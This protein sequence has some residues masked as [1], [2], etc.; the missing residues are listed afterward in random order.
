[1]TGFVGSIVSRFNGA[2][3]IISPRLPGRFESLYYDEPNVINE[4]GSTV[5]LY[6]SA[7]TDADQ[8]YRKGAVITG[9]VKSNV[10]SDRIADEDQRDDHKAGVHLPFEY[11]KQY[12]STRDASIPIH[13]FQ[14]YGQM[15][16]QERLDE[17]R[18]GAKPVQGSDFNDLANGDIHQM[19]AHE[20]INEF[21]KDDTS[22]SIMPQEGLPH[23]IE[24]EQQRSEFPQSVISPVMSQPVEG[25]SGRHPDFNF[26]ASVVQD[27]APVVKISIGR[28]EVRAVPA[29]NSSKPREYGAQKP[30][31]SLD[32]Y[33]QKR[34]KRP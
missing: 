5:E 7:A 24:K 14:R 34:N 28:I 33:L 30:Q 32:E 1:M 12:P 4:S 23:L 13:E 25:N 10:N 8:G 3:N 19:N 27:H 6:Q 31:I 18:H 9:G 15:E 26:R 11:N 21:S 16:E 2:E 20:R 22:R 17:V 29:S